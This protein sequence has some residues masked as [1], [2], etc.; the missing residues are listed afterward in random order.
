[1]RMAI[2]LFAQERMSFAP[3]GARKNFNAN[4]VPR[5]TAWAKFFRPSGPAAERSTRKIFAKQ[6]ES[7]R[8]KPPLRQPRILP[9]CRD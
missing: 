6:M 2:C 5:L 4:R 7:Q 8:Q 3:A 9:L 1:V